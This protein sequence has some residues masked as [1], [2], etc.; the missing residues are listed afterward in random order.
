MISNAVIK[1]ALSSSSTHFDQVYSA[2][3]LKVVR[4]YLSDLNALRGCDVSCREKRRQAGREREKEREA[5]VEGRP[6]LRLD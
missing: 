6:E 1:Q 3:S 5:E 4:V 2:T